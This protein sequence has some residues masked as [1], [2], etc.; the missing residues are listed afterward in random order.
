MF[1]I[2]PLETPVATGGAG[3]ATGTI[4]TPVPVR[5]YIMGVYV[6]YIDSPP[7]GTTD[8]TVETA[9]THAPAQT[10]LAIVNGATDGWRYPQ[11]IA[12][13][14]TSGAAIA[15]LYS[16]GVPVDD[17]IKVTMAQANDNDQ[18][19]VWLLVDGE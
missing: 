13:L 3:A 6:Q 4:T 12:H 17:F 8:V 14:N 18:V 19:K 1:V 10:V 7:A 9:G 11:T 16:S 15:D 5:G 2:G